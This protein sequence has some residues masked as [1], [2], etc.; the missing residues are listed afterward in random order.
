M[1]T[2]YSIPRSWYRRFTNVA[3]LASLL[4]GMLALER[5]Q[6]QATSNPPERLT[7]QGYV[8][9]ANGKVLG[10]TAPK[11]YD[12]VFRIFDAQTGGT[13]KWAEQQTV[14]VDKGYFSVL[15]GEGT[16]VG[17]PR[18][19]LN[20]VFAGADAS[21]RYVEITVKGIGTPDA[22]IAPRLRL[23]TSPY[24]FLARNANS[25]VT[26]TGQSL[27]TAGVGVLQIAAPLQTAGGNSRGSGATDLQTS[28]AANDQV[29]SGANSVLVGGS[30]NRAAAEFS[31]V[32]AGLENSAL[33]ASS[34][35]VAGFQN[36]AT[37]ID[38]FIGGGGVN[39]AEGY[40]SV[41]GGGGF[42]YAAKDHSVVV[43]GFKNTANGINASV[44]GGAE[45]NA[46]GTTAGIGGGF[47]NHATGLE[48][49]V[50]GG[51]L[52]TNTAPRGFI[53]AGV[54]N[55]VTFDNAV[56]VGGTR[57]Q[58]I[59]Q[60]AFVGGGED[61][62]ASGLRAVVG[63]GGSNVASGVDS[64]ISG[65]FGHEATKP[66]ATIGGGFLNKA[67]GDHATVA[68]GH[69][70]WADGVN[71]T[72]GG[73]F[74][75]WAQGLNAFVGAGESHIAS[76]ANSAVVAGFDNLASGN[77][78]TVASG[79]FNVASGI[80]SF[81]AGWRCEATGFESVALGRKAKSRGDG[82]FTYA[83]RTDVDFAP[84][85]VNSFNVRATGGIHFYSNG[86][87]WLDGARTGVFLPPN[88]SS[89]AFVSDRNA[90]KNFEALDYKEV[91][92][93]LDKVPVTAWHY[94]ADADD[95]TKNVG[96]I[97]QDFKQTFYPGRDDKSITTLEL[98]G[99][100]LAAIKGLREV[101]KEKD[102]EIQDLKKQM[103]EMKEL[104]EKVAAKS[105]V[106]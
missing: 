26:S 98:D 88:S 29:A 82:I 85:Y 96:P 39:L 56:V 83:D 77:S 16:S 44:G 34:A 20:V 90:K 70:N 55:K 49:F 38:S 50:A 54:N 99:V 92:E 47:R 86:V 59:G 53:G 40:R 2:S 84:T 3:F 10:E 101:V 72:V 28:R 37:N 8:V 6:A 11:N 25:I 52:N 23:L 41:I 14:T 66:N 68:G 106:Q 71:A 57:N 19:D 79:D 42:N 102:Q 22:T 62:A 9:D 30:K 105:N 60:A 74:N 33:G 104:L 76:A 45:N 58:A 100:E 4:G 94:K 48:S 69:G 24:A 75:N 35:V 64:V 17:Q 32:G 36:K 67:R 21:D 51:T 15:L 87:G 43:G 95:S 91:L 81:V 1:R 27:F 103:K 93:K 80:N 89:W 63:G 13:V 18:P 97:A 73:G 7:Y 65:G 46:N 5:L 78:A 12:V 31:F 61:N